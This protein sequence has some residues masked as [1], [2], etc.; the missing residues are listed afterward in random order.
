MVT[1]C[2]GASY[3]VCQACVS[4]STYSNTTNAATCTSCTTCT[5]GSYAATACTAT[6]N[7]VC[8]PCPAGSSCPSSDSCSVIS[9]PI[10]SYCLGGAAQPVACTV[11]T[12]GQFQLQCHSQNAVCSVCPAGYA[13]SK[14]SSQV[15]CGNTAV[16]P[17][18]H[19]PLTSFSIATVSVAT[20]FN[21][22]SAYYEMFDITTGTYGNGRYEAYLSSK[23]SAGI[24][25][26][27]LVD[28]ST[29]DVHSW[30]YTY[31]SSNGQ[32]SGTKYQPQPLPIN[33]LDLWSTK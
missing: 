25:M 11:C 7:T 15:T 19:P 28:F 5:S 6:S 1:A 12:T 13:C 2:S 27:S 17:I 4:G 22:Q 29:R 18:Q 16:T 14:P 8:Q 3:A 21:G 23:A 24:K 33:S 32:Y 20:T 30:D 26:S 31:I 9:C 10:N